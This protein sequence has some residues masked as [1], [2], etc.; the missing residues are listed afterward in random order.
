MDQ[1]LDISPVSFNGLAFSNGD[2]WAL[3]VIFMSFNRIL[4]IYF[5]FYWYQPPL[6]HRFAR[7]ICPQHRIVH[8][9]LGPGAMLGGLLSAAEDALLRTPKGDPLPLLDRW[10][11]GKGPWM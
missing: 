9:R 3:N 1:G 7:L 5:T 6:D 11:K 4:I 8:L 10:V 2:L